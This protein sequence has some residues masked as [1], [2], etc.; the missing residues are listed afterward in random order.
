VE[1]NPPSWLTA[2]GIRP[3]SGHMQGT[4]WDA[5]LWWQRPV[6][7]RSAAAGH[8]C[9]PPCEHKT[10]KMWETK[11]TNRVSEHVQ[12]TILCSSR[13]RVANELTL[14]LS[15]GKLHHRRDCPLLFAVVGSPPF[16]G[17]LRFG[18]GS[19]L[20]L[21][22]TWRDEKSKGTFFFEDVRGWS[23]VM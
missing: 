12:S 17:A 19:G 23:Y 22:R 7:G 5:L 13:R 20:A 1:A 6:P 18:S 14:F 4:E 15:F 3:C 8:G 10:T 9:A 16:C 11:Q 2:S 21:L